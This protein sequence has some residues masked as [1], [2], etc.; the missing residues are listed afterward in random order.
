MWPRLETAAKINGTLIPD[1][2]TKCAPCHA[3]CVDYCAS[4]GTLVL[5]T[6]PARLVRAQVSRSLVSNL[7]PLPTLHWCWGSWMEINRT[8]VK[9]YMFGHWQQR[10]VIAIQKSLIRPFL[11]HFPYGCLQ[12][13]CV[14]SLAQ[15]ALS[16][17]TCLETLALAAGTVVGRSCKRGWIQVLGSVL[18]DATKITLTKICL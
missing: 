10:I 13:T 14:N 4:G 5:W 18:V 17:A 9:T 15:S 1:F 11:T 6:A 8:V 2:A 16:V 3:L 12:P 7:N